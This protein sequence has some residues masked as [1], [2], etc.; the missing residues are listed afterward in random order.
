MSTTLNE[1]DP[2]VSLPNRTVKKRF[3][4][5]RWGAALGFAL[6]VF[7]AALPSF[8]G[9]KWIYEPLLQRL[10]KDKFDLS[11]D[12][13]K[14]RWLSPLEFRGIAISNSDN[15]ADAKPAIP[16]IS[17][18]SIQTNQGLLGYLLNGRNVGRIQI[19]QPKVDIA[20]LENGSNLE[21]LVK[22]L[23]DSRGDV[24]PKKEK[25]QPKLDIDVAI[26][27]LS[28]EVV[29]ANGSPAIQVIPPMN[30]D[31][32]YRALSE[33]PV[34]IVQPMQVLQKAQL[35]PELVRLGL[36]MAVPLLAKSAWFDGRISLSTQEVRVPLIN[37]NQSTGEA[38]LTLHEVR[39]GPSEP[40]I[41]GALDALANLRGKE[42]SHELVF[43]DGSDVV[44][45]VVD[46]KV[47]HSGLEAGLPKLDPR[48]QIAT[49]GTVGLSDRSLDLA[50]E[51]P[52]PVEQLAR[53]EKIQQIGVPRVKLPIGGT[54][55][56]P[57]VKW[58]VMRGESA[59]LLAV[60]AGRLQSDAPITSTVVDAISGITEGQADQTIEAAADFVRKLRERRAQANA[61]RAQDETKST[62]ETKPERR[63]PFRDALKKALGTE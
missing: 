39:S 46:Q 31:I 38:V 53:R 33:E 9:S 50:I 42:P 26:R 3:A 13:V 29:Q 62:D 56:H 5:A 17:I 4:W 12:T 52:I 7:I 28:V 47:F 6:L 44:V 40:L 32:A 58:E 61:E 34:V 54:L 22:S 19:N 10:A 51:I 21:R 20:L 8:L 1:P 41:V 2:K 59:T 45:K 36:G 43:V 24:Q 23:Q 60:I 63:R 55:D 37:P 15:T 57:E 11:I 18:Q 14:L 27:G 16:L 35:T 48:L 25:S 30:A 49:E